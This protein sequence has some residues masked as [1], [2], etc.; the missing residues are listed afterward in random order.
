MSDAAT[1]SKIGVPTVTVG[2]PV[3]NGENFIESAIQSILEQ[4]YTDFE[5]VISDNAST[6]RTEAI[7]KKYAQKDSR[8]RYI[9]NVVNIGAS[10]NVN[11]LIDLCASKYFKIAA[12][13]D[14]LLPEYLETCVSVLEKDSSIAL[15]HCK[16][17]YV[18]ATGAAIPYSVERD[19]YVDESSGFVWAFDPQ[20]RH[21]DSRNLS[22]RFDDFIRKTVVTLEIWGVVRNEMLQKVRT[23]APYF[24]SDRVTLADLI[25]L[26]RF[27]EVDEVLF[28]KRCHVD[29]VTIQSVEDRAAA[30]GA[31]NPD[32]VRFSGARCFLDY[33]AL[34]NSARLPISEKL[35][36]YLTVARLVIRKQTMKKIFVPG[37][38]NY[39]GINFNLWGVRS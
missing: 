27:V 5:L 9:R 16:T 29:Q 38:Y 11:Q 21:L 32:T 35:R 23:L 13:D 2:M 30:C 17:R 19:V 25:L 12:H 8:I 14:V 20:D 26:G 6:D 37:P 24:G 39:F 4:T 7:C 15:C 22:E 3:F 31:T 1:P 34:I 36:C 28:L 33:L 10:R 18:D